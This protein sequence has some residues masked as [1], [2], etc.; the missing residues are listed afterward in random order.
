M[1]RNAFYIWTIGNRNVGKRVVP[2]DMILIDIM[3]KY[4][5]E[6]FYQAER[7]IF[8]KNQPNKNNFSSTME[9]EKILIFHN[10]L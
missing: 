10:E 7:T 5:I 2:N 6:L 1:K 8:N 4:G 9:K 3:K